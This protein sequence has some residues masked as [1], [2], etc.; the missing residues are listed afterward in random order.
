MKSK[1]KIVKFRRNKR[2]HCAYGG[3]AP[4]TY[5]YGNGEPVQLWD[6]IGFMNGIT[7]QG[8]VTQI[9]FSRIFVHFPRMPIP[10]SENTY[11][12]INSISPANGNIL[13]ETIYLVSRGNEDD[14]V[15]AIA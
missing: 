2:S 5:V 8:Y 6:V 14:Y 9:T 1:T 12:S 15:I 3:R 11:S 4:A 13:D 7:A 10:N